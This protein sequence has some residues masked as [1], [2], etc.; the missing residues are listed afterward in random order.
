M[1]KRILFVLQSLR[2][3]GAERVQV[4]VAEALILDTPV[5]STDCT[6]PNEV[7]DHGRFGM[8]VENSEN[9]LYL[10]LKYLYQEPPLVEYYKKQARERMDFFD[11]EKL[12]KKITD[13]FKG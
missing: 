3:G 11:E 7:L 4:T 10:G 8:L 12:L 5:L 13:L 6:G 9:G 2:M 1:K